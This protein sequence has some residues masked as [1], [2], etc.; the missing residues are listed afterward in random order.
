MPNYQIKKITTKEEKEKGIQ[1]CSSSIPD[2]MRAKARK[3]SAYKFRQ[4]GKY[5]ERAL[6]GRGGRGG[7]QGYVSEGGR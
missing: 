1:R 7:V 3:S 6:R 5:H 4:S 2:S